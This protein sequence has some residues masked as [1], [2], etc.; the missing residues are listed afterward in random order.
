MPIVLPPYNHNK[1]WMTTQFFTQSD[2]YLY[3]ILTHTHS[4]MRRWHILKPLYLIVFHMCLLCDM[5]IKFL[6]GYSKISNWNTCTA[7]ND[8]IAYDSISALCPGLWPTKH[9]LGLSLSMDP[10]NEKRYSFVTTSLIGWVQA[11]NQSCICFKHMLSR[12][13][14]GTG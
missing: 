12:A 3:K 14:S 8:D 6:K 10:A 5:F 7:N 13:R 2:L 9:I 1:Y 11:K 4:F